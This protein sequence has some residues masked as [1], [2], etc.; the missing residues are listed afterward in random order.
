[1]QIDAVG[2][3]IDVI[4]GTVERDIETVLV[5]D[6]F[7]VGF[8]TAQPARGRAVDV[9]KDDVDAVFMLQSVRHHVKLQR[10][11]RAQDQVVAQHGAEHLGRAFLRQLFQA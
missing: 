10:A 11:D 8:R 1:M 9:L 4:V 3:Q 7:Q 5:G 6:R 2:C